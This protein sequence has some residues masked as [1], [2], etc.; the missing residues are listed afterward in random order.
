MRT[1]PLKG[2]LEKSPFNQG[3]KLGTDEDTSGLTR[4]FRD[5]ASTKK[6]KED[7]ASGRI[8]KE[9]DKISWGN[10]GAKPIMEDY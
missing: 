7:K 3:T 8:D 2:L 4:T 5:I 1:S 6:N 9:G 10:P